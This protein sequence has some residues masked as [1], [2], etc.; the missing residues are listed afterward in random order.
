MFGLENS[1]PIVEFGQNFEIGQLGQAALYGLTMLLIGMAT[2]FAVLCV[3]WLCLVLFKYAFHH[4]AT[5][6]KE[7]PAKVVEAAPAPVYAQAA[8][9]ADDGE[10]I[11]VIAA[12]IAMAE[13]ECAGAKFRVV[14]FRRK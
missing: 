9:S 2:V 4:E 7:K 1:K 5:E 14:S 13:D 10:M 11:A 12:A 8:Q 6:K 3:I